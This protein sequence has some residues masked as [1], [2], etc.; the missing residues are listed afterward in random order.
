MDATRINYYLAALL[1]LL[2]L[3]ALGLQL[4]S[5]YS[6]Y[7]YA[8]STSTTA[9]KARPTDVIDYQASTVTSSH[10]FGRLPDDYRLTDS[11]TIPTTSMHTAAPS[12][13]ALTGRPGP[14]A[15]V[16]ASTDK[17]NCNRC[18]PIEWYYPETDN[19]KPFTSLSIK[20]LMRTQ[21]PASIR[22]ARSL[23]IFPTVSR[24]LFATI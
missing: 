19:W 18:T 23:R 11:A 7:Q 21:T 6:T 24:S 20:P 10:L 15:W 12:S 3:V 5:A 16:A 22:A 1:A 2:V 8:P 9:P 14:I 4:R 13:K 17:R